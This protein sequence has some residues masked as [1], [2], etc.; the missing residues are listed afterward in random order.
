MTFL[1]SVTML[2][3]TVV[4]MFVLLQIQKGWTLIYMMSLVTMS[5]LESADDTDSEEGLREEREGVGQ[6]EIEHHKAVMAIFYV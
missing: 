2:V 6:E 1:S 3:I 4:I 5:G